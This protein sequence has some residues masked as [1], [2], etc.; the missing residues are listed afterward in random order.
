MRMAAFTATGQTFELRNT[1]VT[2]GET[3]A[4]NM[5]VIKDTAMYEP[6]I[7]LTNKSAEYTGSIYGIDTLG[8]NDNLMPDGMLADFLT[9]SLGDEYLRI[10]TPDS[11]VETTGT[12]I[13][14]LDADMETVLETY[15]FV[16]FG[17]VDMDG[18]VGAS[19][20]DIVSYYE[21]NY[22]GID[23]L[24]QFMAGDLDGDAWP[25]AADGDTM[26]Y[27]E[28]NYMGMP[29]QSDVAAMASFNIYEL[30]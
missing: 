5:L 14:V 16:Y 19:D 13:E 15:V 10:T 11:G 18:L 8:W 22:M 1:T 20:A 21:A 29:M 3:A 17:D 27:Y 25:T 7:D 6:V 2:V 12:I 28:A 26:S 24:A 23:T 9:T 4:M 30:I